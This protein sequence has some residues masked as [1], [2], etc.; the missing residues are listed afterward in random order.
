MGELTQAVDWGEV[1][2]KHRSLLLT[3]AG[4]IVGTQLAEDAVQEAFLNAVKYADRFQGRCAPSTWM[5][6]L[7]F[8]AALMMLRS[9]DDDWQESVA[10][11]PD[12]PDPYPDPFKQAV[13]SE[14]LDRIVEI[15]EQLPIGAGM[16][17][18]LDLRL[19]EF[20]TREIVELHGTSYAAEKCRWF[21]MKQ[22]IVDEVAAQGM[23]I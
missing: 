1:F 4:K 16:R 11:F 3:V 8:R 15:I 9:S 22:M 19:R 17:D 7:T 6:T 2:I 23:R 18:S 21:R 10:D 14:A 20:S 5:Y 12:T 13:N